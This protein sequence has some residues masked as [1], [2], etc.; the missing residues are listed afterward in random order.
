LDEVRFGILH[1]L[2]SFVKLLKK[3]QQEGVLPKLCVFLKMDNHRN[4]RYRYTLAEQLILLTPQYSCSQVQQYMLPISL[5][6]AID[7]VAQVRKIGV[8]LLATIVGHV[9]YANEPS[10]SNQAREAIQ[11]Q[12]VYELIDKLSKSNKWSHRQIFVFL[13]DSLT[14]RQM[15]PFQILTDVLLPVL[16]LLKQDPVPN[17]RLALA[18]SLASTFFRY[19]GL[20]A[21]A[22]VCQMLESLKADSDK[23]VRSNAQQCL[24]IS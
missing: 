4:W 2:A 17:V 15:V 22:T 1:N 7:K 8:E 14:E 18:R 5:S 6:L 16:F 10:I 11:K 21:N 13:C 19:E 20:R 9:F 23:D 24:I 3:P 12:V